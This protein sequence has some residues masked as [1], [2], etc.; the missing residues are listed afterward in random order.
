MYKYRYIMLYRG[1][2]IFSLHLY[3]IFVLLYYSL[4]FLGFHDIKTKPESNFFFFLSRP[5]MRHRAES[6][7]THQDQ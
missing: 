3:D 5:S 6:H 4:S 2:I 1:F 7:V